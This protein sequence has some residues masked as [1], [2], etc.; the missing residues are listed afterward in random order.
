[1]FK[2]SKQELIYRISAAAETV[3]QNG[4]K[5]SIILFTAF[6][7]IFCELASIPTK[8]KIKSNALNSG[9]LN[10]LD[11]ALSVSLPDETTI[12]GDPEEFIYC[13]NVKI[14]TAQGATINIPALCISQRDVI[15][16]SLGSPENQN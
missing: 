15:G 4:T 12:P 3:S 10:S 7:M 14:T 11:L 6:G 5:N 16:V 8:E 2:M 13:K 9:A 1:M